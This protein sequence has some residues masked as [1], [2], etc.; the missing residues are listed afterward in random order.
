MICCAD[1]FGL[2]VVSVSVLPS[3]KRS[4]LAGWVGTTSE[5]LVPLI[6][7]VREHV[8]AGAKL[9]ADD[10]PVPGAGAGQRPNGCRC[11]HG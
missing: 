3:L 11:R 1:D 2:S 8:I 5:L 7:A 9:H 4:T 6:A 10:T